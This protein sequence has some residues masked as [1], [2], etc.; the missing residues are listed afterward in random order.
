MDISRQFIIGLLR[1][2]DIDPSVFELLRSNAGQV[3]PVLREVASGEAGDADTYMRKNAIA[4]L[5]VCGD[6]SCAD[7]L[8]GL[9]D[10]ERLEFRANAIRSLASIAPTAEI[11]RQLEARLG[12]AG[13]EPSEGKLIVRTLDAVGGAGSAKAVR[14]FEKRFQKRQKGS[15]GL[16]RD[17]GEINRIIQS[18]EARGA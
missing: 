18:L 11:L 13:L 8:A 5:G 7:T 14:A 16:E 3:N 10:H 2:L 6:A 9:L 4:L 17:L 15:P 1:Q 12:E